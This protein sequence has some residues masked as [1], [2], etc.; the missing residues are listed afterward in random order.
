MLGFQ[1]HASMPGSSPLVL[2][3]QVLKLVLR[4]AF[5]SQAILSPSPG[6]SLSVGLHTVHLHSWLSAR[7]LGGSEETQVI[8]VL[9]IIGKQN[10]TPPQYQPR[11]GT[12]AALPT[13]CVSSLSD[14]SPVCP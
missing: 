4:Q 10:K 9:R 8:K 11:D 5:A 3:T 13:S 12:S 14:Q 2:G 6:S 7:S 1:A